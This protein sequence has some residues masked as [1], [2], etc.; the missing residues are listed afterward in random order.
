MFAMATANGTVCIQLYLYLHD[1]CVSY[2]C[3]AVCFMC[4]MCIWAKRLK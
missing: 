3:F 1:L 2:V 4:F